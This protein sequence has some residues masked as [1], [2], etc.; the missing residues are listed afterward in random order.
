MFVDI[1]MS[2]FLKYLKSHPFLLKKTVNFQNA[3][4][5]KSISVSEWQQLARK[6]NE[7]IPRKLQYDMSIKLMEFIQQRSKAKLGYSPSPETS[8]VSYVSRE[9]A[10]E[11]SKQKV[12]AKVDYDESHIKAANMIQK[13]QRRKSVEKKRSKGKLVKHKI[14]IGSGWTEYYDSNGTPYYVNSKNETQWEYPEN[15]KRKTFTAD[16][17]REVTDPKTGHVYYYNKTTK[18]ST[19]DKPY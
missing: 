5:E 9:K 16:E 11:M 15:I 6:R 3:L 13:V 8:T 19:W 1:N 17:W 7:V 14:Y 18:C 10:V 12:E 2:G 4:R